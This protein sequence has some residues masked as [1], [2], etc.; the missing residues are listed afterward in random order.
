MENYFDKLWKKFNKQGDV[1]RNGLNIKKLGSILESTTNE[2]EKTSVLNPAVYQEGQFLHIFYRAIDRNNESS[3][4]YAKL[5]GPTKVVERMKTPIITKSFPY[6]SKGVEDPRIV[7]LNDTFYLTYVA[8]DGQN[9]LTAYATSKDLKK[10]TKKGLIG[11]LMDYHK[12]GGIFREQKLKDRYSM[13]QAYYEEMAG[14]DVKIWFKDAFL[15]PQKIKDNYAMI[16]RVLP[17]IQLICFKDF[18]QLKKKSFWENYIKNI[19][20]YVVLE[21][22]Y[23]FES[24]N[25]GGGAVPLYTKYGWLI[26]FHAVEELN[27][28]RVYHASAALLD[29]NNPLKVIGRLE[30]PLFSPEEQW[31]KQGFV[32]NVVFPTGNAIFGKH[33]YMYYGAADK[34]IA[35]A[36]VN[37]E[38]LIK[39]LK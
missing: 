35:V 14:E 24:R 38:Q 28:A 1:K 16:I 3:I 39:K 18:K 5:K 4:G 6:E 25:I 7:K 13:F 12:A 31:E 17:D 30:E 8:H 36:R 19:S 11:P 37:L 32:N 9:A 27:K 33:L 2:F 29:K 10:F 20:H 26:I 15:F 22:K 23:W 34:R 21:N